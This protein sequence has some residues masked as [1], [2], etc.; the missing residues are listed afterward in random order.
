MK[1]SFNINGTR[2]S[3]AN[4]DG[5]Y[6]NSKYR[7]MVFDYDYKAWVSLNGFNTIASA[8]EYAEEYVK[9]IADFEES[10]VF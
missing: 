8:R 10:G 6:G 7:L 5:Y 2:F 9:R 4:N 1:R 3:I